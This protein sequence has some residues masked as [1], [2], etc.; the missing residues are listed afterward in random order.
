M[1]KPIWRSSFNVAGRVGLGPYTEMIECIYDLQTVTVKKRFLSQGIYVLENLNNT[2]SYFLK[3][4]LRGL[5]EEILHE[6]S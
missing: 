5:A 1:K 2:G 6:I 4:K 3:D